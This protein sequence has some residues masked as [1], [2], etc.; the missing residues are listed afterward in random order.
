MAHADFRDP[1]DPKDRSFQ[2]HPH[3]YSYIELAYPNSETYVGATRE[4]LAKAQRCS[5]ELLQYFVH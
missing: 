3:C 4:A 5:L 1:S 2:P